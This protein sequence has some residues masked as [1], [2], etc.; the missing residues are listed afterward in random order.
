M[1][2]YIGIDVF[3]YLLLEWLVVNTI[4]NTK[5]VTMDM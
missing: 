1:L 2:L 3:K 5:S 4:S